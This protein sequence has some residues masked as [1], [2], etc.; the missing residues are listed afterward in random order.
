MTRHDDKYSRAEWILR[1]IMALVIIMAFM[2]PLMSPEIFAATPV[3]ISAADHV[4]GGETFDV[5][6]TFGS[7]SVG[8][9]DAQMLYDPDKL[10]YL[11]GGSSSG[12]TGYIQ[13]K[14]AGTDGSITFDLEFQAVAE[15]DAT[16]DVTVNEMYDL[17]EMYLDTPSA[18]KTITISGN[19]N[20]E[21]LITEEAA[22]DQTEEATEPQ[23]VDEKPDE[24]GQTDEDTAADD[25][26]INMF[27][28]IT[29]IGL[30]ILIVIISVI[31]A[32]RRKR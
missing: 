5:T 26:G 10:T 19:A 18:S 14:S 7:G 32:S 16:L 2:I 29:A 20:E 1:K 31:L 24:E 12:N 27:F 28:I 8:R 3:T 22:D 30:V 25:G 21:E 6:V 11:T 23:G 15:G 4:K 13:L 17:D 9:V